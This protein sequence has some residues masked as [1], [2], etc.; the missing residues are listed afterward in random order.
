MGLGVVILKVM[1]GVFEVRW[2]WV[3]G[4]VELLGGGCDERVVIGRGTHDV[5]DR[6]V[7]R[8]TSRVRVSEEIVC[9]TLCGGTQFGGE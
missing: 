2:K 1:L 9:M 7:F 4:G 5:F 3:C 6:L 8:T